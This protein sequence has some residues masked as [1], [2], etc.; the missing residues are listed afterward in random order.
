MSIRRLCCIQND[1]WITH[2]SEASSEVTSGIEREVRRRKRASQNTKPIKNTKT[3]R[4]RKIIMYSHPASPKKEGAAWAEHHQDLTVRPEEYIVGGY[5]DKER[6]M[7][8]RI[9]MNRHP[10]PIKMEGCSSSIKNNP[11]LRQ[12]DIEQED[13]ATTGS[14]K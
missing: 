4:N 6:E 14:A 3:E 13:A 5:G 2:H 11:F 9:A 12:K 1:H 7:E 8:N 10:A